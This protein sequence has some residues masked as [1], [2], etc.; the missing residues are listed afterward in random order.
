MRR[1]VTFGYSW[2]NYI[3]IQFDMRNTYKLCIYANYIAR[4][5]L[6]GYFVR[7]VNVQIENGRKIH[8]LYSYESDFLNVWGSIHF[9]N[10]PDFFVEFVLL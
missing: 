3:E 8:L 9:L 4:R 7:Y 10:V 2:T 1:Y 6:Y 5:V